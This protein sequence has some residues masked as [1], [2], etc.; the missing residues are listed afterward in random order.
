MARA[1]RQSVA[2]GDRK[3]IEEVKT[4]LRVEAIG[5]RIREQVGNLLTLRERSL[6]YNADFGIKKDPNH[7]AVDGLRSADA[8]L[9]IF[10]GHNTNNSATHEAQKNSVLFFTD[11]FPGNAKAATD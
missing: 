2:V 1:N 5:R 8:S 6:A 10:R 3:F 9:R 7:R 11:C 4:H